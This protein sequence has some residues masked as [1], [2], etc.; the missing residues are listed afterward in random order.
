[1]WKKLLTAL[2]ITALLAVYAQPAAC[3]QT[4]DADVHGAWSSAGHAALADAL[5][6]LANADV[7]K[8]I[9]EAC[10]S[11]AYLQSHPANA[12]IANAKDF[13]YRGSNAYHAI[14]NYVAAARYLYALARFYRYGTAVDFTAFDAA[15]T[16]IGR[17]YEPTNRQDIDSD[18]QYMTQFCASLFPTA[19]PQRERLATAAFGML[20]H[21]LGDVYAHRTV[22]PVSSAAV[23]DRTSYGMSSGGNEGRYFVLRD[24]RTSCPEHRATG[25]EAY[26]A[27]RHELLEEAMQ[28]MGEG[29]FPFAMAFARFL[30]YA[31]FGRLF[32]TE[33]PYTFTAED[34]LRLL[35]QATNIPQ[36][37]AS[38]CEGKPCFYAM[39][40]I[41]QL[42]VLQ[43]KDI[44]YFLN[45]ESY[46]SAQGYYEDQA[47][48]NA[49]Y[50]RRY[51]VARAV[52]QQFVTDFG[53]NRAFNP[54]N[55]LPIYTE[56][57]T[58]YCLRLDCLYNYLRQTNK[59]LDTQ[60]N[61]IL[62]ASWWQTR[63]DSLFNYTTI[64]YNGS[65]FIDPSTYPPGERP[66]YE[67]VIPQNGMTAESFY[68]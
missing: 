27:H 13:V 31:L 8:V 25:S 23:T 43:F 14:G 39:Q 3:A 2:L 52:M 40:R 32:T 42:G 36:N 38:L 4:A 24:F 56:Q 29:F 33:E 68:L 63:G 67:T 17:S 7:I 44:K 9:S 5:T 60:T 6:G 49:F 62:R 47:P 10:D 26:R 35:Q 28:A 48:G 1:M 58:A 54:E 51:E 15:L 20:F 46:K 37:A 34:D 57:M 41:T 53:A 59:A 66:V 65:Y 12:G 64:I 22:V 21:L 18:I 30:F 19:M 45:D 61:A 50:Y 11:R 55:F 16:G